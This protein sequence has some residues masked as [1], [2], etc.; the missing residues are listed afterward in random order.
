MTKNA[1]DLNAYAAKALAAVYET[2]DYARMHKLL[3]DKEPRL[4]PIS[5]DIFGME[6][7]AARLALACRAWEENCGEN[8]VKGEEDKKALLRHIMNSFQSPKFLNLATAFSNY[9]H[10]PRVEEMPAIAV[11]EH[12]FKRLG[13]PGTV[14]KISGEEVSDGFK[15]MV[16]ESESF[17]SSFEN[18]FFE[19][20]N[21]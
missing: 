1:K 5:A 19:F 9:L 14:R 3:S 17:R 18:D 11:S 6:Y 15:S 4:K 8:G 21:S 13:I 16:A 7:L 10:C 20:V 2:Q 12:L